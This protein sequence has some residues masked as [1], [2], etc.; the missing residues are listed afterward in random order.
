ML[1][2]I[3]LVE[4]ERMALIVDITSCMYGVELLDSRSRLCENWVV[5]WYLLVFANTFAFLMKYLS[6]KII[7]IHIP[8]RMEATIV[9]SGDCVEQTRTPSPRPRRRISLIDFD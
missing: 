9:P 3:D 5:V 4:F 2:Y 8:I 1:F 6:G 7:C